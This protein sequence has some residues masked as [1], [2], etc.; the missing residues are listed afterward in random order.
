[1]QEGCRIVLTF[2]LISNA[3]GAVPSSSDVLSQSSQLEDAL[4]QWNAHENAPMAVCYALDHKYT[5]QGLAPAA[6]K[7]EDLHRFRA[8]SNACEKNGNFYAMLGRIENVISRPQGDGEGA[9]STYQ[10]TRIGVDAIMTSHGTMLEWRIWKF[11]SDLIIKQPFYPNNPWTYSY[12]QE[13]DESRNR[14]LI[15]WPDVYFGGEFLG[16]EN[17]DD[18]KVYTDTVSGRQIHRTSPED[19]KSVTVVPTLERATPSFS[20]TP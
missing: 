5:K 12:D 8:V 18:N 16:N 15:R 20:N 11:P 4:S 3:E 6:L 7:G 10:S 14:S 19:M 17:A 13:R 1:M 9:E 2:N